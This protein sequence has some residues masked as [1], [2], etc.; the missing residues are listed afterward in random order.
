MPVEVQFAGDAQAF[1]QLASR[2]RQLISREQDPALMSQS[3]YGISTV[4]QIA[5][6]AGGDLELLDRLV[7]LSQSVRIQSQDDVNIALD[8]GRDGIGPEHEDIAA[9]G[10][11]ALVV[12]LIV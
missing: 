11:G 7:E 10:G 1:V 2:P 5:K 8:I 4:T 6:D 3:I 12:A 9:E